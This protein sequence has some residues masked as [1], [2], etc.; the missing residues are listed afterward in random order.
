[1]IQGTVPMTVPAGD[2]VPLRTP[3]ASRSESTPLPRPARPRPGHPSCPPP[4]GHPAAGS[5][6]DAAARRQY[7]N[8][9]SNSNGR[10]CS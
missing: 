6:E 5:R 10:H 3:R 2:V 1:M 4:F 9:T 7:S 8:E